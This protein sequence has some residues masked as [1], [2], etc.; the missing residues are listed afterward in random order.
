MKIK[1]NDLIFQDQYKTL[2]FKC[3][4]P[5]AD[6]DVVTQLIENYQ[7]NFDEIRR[8]EALAKK[9]DLP[10]INKVQETLAE[11]NNIELRKY[12]DRFE[13]ILKINKKVEIYEESKKF[14]EYYK[15][16]IHEEF[17]KL[18]KMKKFLSKK[19][20]VDFVLKEEE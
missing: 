6:L 7:K 18:L 8:F 10:L 1:V 5:T 3:L 9:L 13:I 16:Y 19:I 4:F 11:I 20:E 15:K 12:N 17:K 2:Y 14:N